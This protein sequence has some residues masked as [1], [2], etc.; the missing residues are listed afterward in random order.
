MQAMLLRR[1]PG[2]STSVRVI[3]HGKGNLN[4]QKIAPEPQRFS[5]EKEII[6]LTVLQWSKKTEKRAGMPCVAR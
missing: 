4:T 2:V 5:G 3:G 6:A 1:L